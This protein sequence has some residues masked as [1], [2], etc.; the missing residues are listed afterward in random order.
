MIS[1]DLLAILVCPESRTPLDIADD[2]V[3]A[4]LNRAIA[5]GKVTNKGGAPVTEKISAGLIRR[6][7][8]VLY[9]IIDRI[10][11]L[12]ADEGIALGPLTSHRQ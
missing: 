2:D 6:D 5:A 1:K 4:V 9:P 8:A 10:P 7:R 12:L 3:L 11:I